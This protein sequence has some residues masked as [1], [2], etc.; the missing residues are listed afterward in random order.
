[1]SHGPPCCY[2][3]PASSLNRGRWASFFA[4]RKRL[5][6][7][8]ILCYRCVYMETLQLLGTALGLGALAGINL[9]L[10]VFVAGLAIQQGWVSLSPQYAELAVLGH[11][12]VVV[13]AGILYAL[14]FFA[15]KIPWVDSVWDLVHSVIRP[16][17]GAFLAVKALGDVNPIFDVT[18]ALLA[19]G[20]AFSTHSMKAGMHLIANSSPEPFSNIALSLAEDA[21]VLGGL[22]LLSVNPVIL[23][24]LVILA[25]VAIGYLGPKIARTVKVKL[26]LAWRKLNSP[27]G[28]SREVTELPKRLSSDADVQLHGV[29]GSAKIAWAVPCIAAGSKRL[30]ANVAGYL[31]ALEDEQE[32]LVFVGKGLFR[33]TAQILD[34]SGYKAAQEP[35][36]LSEN[37]V[38]YSTDR[39]PKEVFFFDRPNRHL[40]ELVVRAIESRL[41]GSNN[42][43]RGNAPDSSDPV[44]E[45][46]PP[47]EP[48][49]IELKP[50]YEGGPLRFTPEQ[51]TGTGDQR[52]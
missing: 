19:G 36:F 30:R 8:A 21:T 15:D 23:L 22:F 34:F 48:E 37:L 13:I 44:S 10:T 27:A 5:P 33:K 11:P 26:W 40:V 12:V 51:G 1:M 28:A 24:V 42:A 6:F 9:Y 50:A 43:P 18:I 39:R 38:L 52:S 45:P 2:L 41:S 31:I 7:Q 46:L 16:V 4:V 3:F 49:V 14:Q 32:K 20:V 47:T 25:V 17:G 35:K 29:K